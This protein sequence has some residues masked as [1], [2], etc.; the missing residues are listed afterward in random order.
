MR[1]NDT[2]K[3]EINYQN[4]ITI[5]NTERVTTM[6]VYCISDIH[7]DYERFEK[8]LDKINFSQNDT[9]YVIGDVVDRGKEPIRLLIKIMETP[10]I[11]LLEGNHEE[12]MQLALD[13]IHEKRVMHIWRWNGGGVTFNQFIRLEKEQREKILD[14]LSTLPDYMEILVGEKRFY[15]VH[16][17]PSDIHNTRVWERVD[18]DIDYTEMNLGTIIFGHT[19]TLMYM[20][21]DKN[22]YL[23]I[24]HGKGTIGIDCG[25]G[26]S[27]IENRR[28]A[29]LRLDDMKEF[30]V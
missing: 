5:I 2:I 6:S 3:I 1:Y 20:D 17:C 19:P 4:N 18:K 26:H 13:P 8:M 9:M 14:Y 24:F 22:D 28:L 30:Y 16:G 21:V 15:L 10:N 23:K 27:M 12:M 25:C 11:I 29:C 7:G